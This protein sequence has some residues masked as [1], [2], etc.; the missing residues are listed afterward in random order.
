MSGLPTR[1]ALRVDTLAVVLTQTLF[2]RTWMLRALPRDRDR[3]VAAGGR[4]IGRRQAQ[5]ADHNGRDAARGRLRRDTRARGT[6]GR[7][8]GPERYLAS[9]PT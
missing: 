5:A 8:T 4:P 6:R 2:G 7:R 1:E 9:A 3:C